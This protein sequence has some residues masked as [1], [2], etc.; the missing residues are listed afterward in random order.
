MLN[1]AGDKYR[2]ADQ[3]KTSSF[4]NLGF[5]VNYVPFAGN[6]KA[7]THFVLVGNVNN[8]LGNTQVS[9]YHYS[10]SGAVKQPIVPPATRSFMIGVFLSWGVDRTEDVINNNL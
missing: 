7:K 10:Y 5:S 9:G 4:K 1:S 6:L 3:G 2:I 8:V